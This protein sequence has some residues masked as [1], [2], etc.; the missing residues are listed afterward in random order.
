[1][2]HLDWSVSLGT[3][4]QIVL[5]LGGLAA[6]WFNLKGD[7]RD[8]GTKVN[9]MWRPYAGG[10]GVQPMDVRV[11]VLEHELANLKHAVNL[12]RRASER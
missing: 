8:I 1:M 11:G 9:L 4:I 12:A 5:F 2:P 7:V 10:D 6:A 3:V